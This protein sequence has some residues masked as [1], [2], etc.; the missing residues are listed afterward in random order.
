MTTRERRPHETAVT[1]T[2]QA[3]AEKPPE[4]DSRESGDAF[5]QAADAAIDRALS[6]RPEAFLA[7]NR[8]LGGQ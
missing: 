7:Q 4:S 6:G 3:E 5:L 2:G 8:Q 1:R